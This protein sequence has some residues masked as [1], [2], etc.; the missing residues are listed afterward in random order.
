VIM[1]SVLR[2][3]SAGR[4]PPGRD[5]LDENNSATYFSRLRQARS[6]VCN[7]HRGCH[8]EESEMKSCLRIASIAPLLVMAT[9]ARGTTISLDFNTLPS[10]QGWTYR[11]DGPSEADS[12][13]VNGTGTALI[14]DTRGDPAASVG[15][16]IPGIVD[17]SAPFTIRMRARVLTTEVLDPGFPASVLV[18]VASTGLEVFGF[19]LNTT[20]LHAPLFS[21]QTQPVDGGQFHDYRLEASP[22]NMRMFVDDVLVLPSGLPLPVPNPSVLRLLNSSFEKGYAEITEFSFQQAAAIPEPE[23]WLLMFFGSAV[24]AA[25]LYGW[26]RKRERA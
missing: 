15:Y 21:G 23:T 11:S 25:R 6:A 20:L 9:V 7:A 8:R 18:A 12:F 4:R 13:S 2:G 14:L 17:S 5:R 22:G 19:G 1:L 26:G 10:A 24:L 16:E 3:T